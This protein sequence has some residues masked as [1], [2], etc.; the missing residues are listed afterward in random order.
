ML[1]RHG[2][3]HLIN[4]KYSWKAVRRSKG[5]AAWRRAVADDG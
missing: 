5:A 4:L 1:L 3:P 2:K